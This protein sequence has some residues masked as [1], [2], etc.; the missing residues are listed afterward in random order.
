MDP[1]IAYYVVGE[2]GGS[3]LIVKS[4]AVT[5]DLM[6]GAE[7]RMTIQGRRGYIVKVTGGNLESGTIEAVQTVNDPTEP[8]EVVRERL[9]I[10]KRTRGS[11][12]V[13][14]GSIN[15]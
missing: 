12:T 3:T 13:F 11:N 9:R 1:S 15:A 7:R 8:F 2:D 4:S 10:R 14:R 5:T 6:N